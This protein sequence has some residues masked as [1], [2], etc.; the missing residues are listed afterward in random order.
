[1]LKSA[2]MYALSVAA[3]AF[4]GYML[5]RAAKRLPV[6]GAAVAKVAP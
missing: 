5:L 4:V 2:A 1:M 6:V 3:A